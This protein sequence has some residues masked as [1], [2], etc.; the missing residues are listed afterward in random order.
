MRYRTLLFDLD[1]TLLDSYASEQAAFRAAMDVADLADPHRFFTEYER[2][3]HE[4]WADVE[5]GVISPEDVR[6]TRFERFNAHFGIDADPVAMADA[7]VD[8]LGNN[9]ELF[10]GVSD[11]LDRLAPHST[12][13]MVTNGIGQVQRMRVAR[14]G[15][16]RYFPVIAVSGDL[17][18]AK[19]AVEI[20]EWVAAEL[21]GVDKE[22][23]LM[24][25]DSLS[26]DMQ[27][28]ANF[29]ISNAWYNPF[30]RQRPD[31]PAIAHEFHAFDELVDI[32]G[33]A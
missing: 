5:G 13:A 26:S 29:E 3:N 11:M 30:H 23:T 17:G 25:G 9:G 32:V 20:F 8:G 33:I 10:P 15:L 24:I 19:P 4:L 22:S 28:G 6:V 14:L 1:H 27:G 31:S 21:G 7:F 18:F 16:D 12:M 2:I